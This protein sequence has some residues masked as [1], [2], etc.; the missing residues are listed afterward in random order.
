MIT[1][2]LPPRRMARRAFALLVG[3]L[4]PLALV[5]AAGSAVAAVITISVERRGDTIAIEASAL[6]G[7]DA[8]TAWRVL[9]DYGRYPEFIPGLTESRVVAR[10]GPTVIVEQDGYAQVWLLRA[11]VAVTYEIT[12]TP[13]GRVRSRAVAGSL[14]LLDS[15]YRLTPLATGVRL[16]YTGLAATGTGLFGPFE[17]WVIE[18]NATLRFRALAEAMERAAR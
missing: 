3:A 2:T 17:Q 5:L 18:Q 6:L 4:L 16:D 1:M 9:T 10:N 11:P 7:V 12:E 13:P 14:R 15:D 8:A